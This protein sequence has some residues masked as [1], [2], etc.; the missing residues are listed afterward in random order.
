MSLALVNQGGVLGI[1]VASSEKGFLLPSEPLGGIV[2][3]DMKADFYG[4]G[5]E[6]MGPFLVV[7]KGNTLESVP[8]SIRA[9]F[10]KLINVFSKELDDLAVK[11]PEIQADLV[12]KG[13]HITT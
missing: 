13:W 8:K 3:A 9:K 10:G 1:A 6:D 4:E 12:K 11:K 7:P 5:P 2:R